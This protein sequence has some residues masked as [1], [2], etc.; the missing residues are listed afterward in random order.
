MGQATGEEAKAELLISS[1]QVRIDAVRP[2][3][4]G[5]P[6]ALG[7]GDAL[8]DPQTAAR[9]GAVGPAGTRHRKPRAAARLQQA[10]AGFDLDTPAR[11]LELDPMCRGATH[12]VS[13]GEVGARPRGPGGV[14]S[15]A[16]APSESRLDRC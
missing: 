12:P 7:R 5:L 1:M 16:A 8:Q 6:R 2:L 3:A 9:A 15:A 10:H 11:R 13:L 4:S 14:V